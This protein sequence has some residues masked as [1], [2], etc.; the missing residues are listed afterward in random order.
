LRSANRF[1][2][3]VAAVLHANPSR[4]GYTGEKTFLSR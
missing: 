1:C 4:F 3:A 2:Q